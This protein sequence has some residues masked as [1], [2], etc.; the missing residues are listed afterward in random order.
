MGIVFNFIGRAIFLNSVYLLL[1]PSLI[2][3]VLLFFIGLQG[4]MQNYTVQDLLQDENQ[5]PDRNTK[6]Y[7]Q[8]Q[9][10]EKLLLLFSGAK[11]LQTT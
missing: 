1:I 9:L 7:N 4:Y 11:N 5:Q 10:K 2:F 8:I 3:S 6:E